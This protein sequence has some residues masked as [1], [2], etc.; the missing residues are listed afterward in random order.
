MIRDGTVVSFLV[1][2]DSPAY[3]KLEKIAGEPL[4]PGTIID[5]TPLQFESVKNGIIILDQEGR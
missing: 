3:E 5:L 2:N 1:E 4:E